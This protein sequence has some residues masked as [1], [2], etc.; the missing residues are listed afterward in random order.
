M[1]LAASGVLW[2]WWLSHPRAPTLPLPGWCR[3]TLLHT[4][5]CLSGWVLAL[6][7][8]SLVVGRSFVACPVSAFQAYLFSSA[9]T[10]RLL[11]LPLRVPTGLLALAATLRTSRHLAN[12]TAS[13]SSIVS[14]HRHVRHQDAYATSS[15]QRRKGN[16]IAEAAAAA[17]CVSSMINDTNTRS[18]HSIYTHPKSHLAEQGVCIPPPVSPP[19]REQGCRSPGRDRPTGFISVV[20]SAAAATTMHPCCFCITHSAK[21]RPDINRRSHQRDAPLPDPSPPMLLRESEPPRVRWHNCFS[22]THPAS[23]GRRLGRPPSAYCFSPPPATQLVNERGVLATASARTLPC[24]PWPV[25][26]WLQAHGHG[27]VA[28]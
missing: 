12:P 9:R 23:A 25:A 2:L 11:L 24:G 21:V 22:F 3:G 28:G 1:N 18:P 17:A 8:L 13:S 6:L 7:W 26:R 4:S 19:H 5:V 10:P 16:S 15:V 20:S 27:Q 14:K